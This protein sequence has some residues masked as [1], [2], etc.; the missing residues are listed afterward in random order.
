MTKGCHRL[1]A[2][3][4]TFCHHFNRSVVTKSHTFPIASGFRIEIRKFLYSWHFPMNPKFAHSTLKHWEGLK[5]HRHALTPSLRMWV[6][7]NQIF[8]LP[9]KMTA[10]LT[11]HVLKAVYL[12]N[13]IETD[14][15][16]FFKTWLRKSIIY[17]TYWWKS[18]EINKSEFDKSNK[19]KICSKI[20]LE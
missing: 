6:M 1:L 11:K 20:L 4:Q 8:L 12:Q 16:V 19:F 18:S 2:G 3:I 17:F 14:I 7:R 5:K 13:A 15:F 9:V 10:L